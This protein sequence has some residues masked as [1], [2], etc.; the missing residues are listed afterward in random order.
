M[1][2]GELWGSCC[3]L[4]VFAAYVLCFGSA[5]WLSRMQLSR[6]AQ[7]RNMRVFTNRD[8]NAVWTEHERAQWRHAARVDR[9]CNGHL[10]TG[11]KHDDAR[12]ALAT[13]APNRNSRAQTSHEDSQLKFHNSVPP[14]NA[15]HSRQI[16]FNLDYLTRVAR[17]VHSQNKTFFQ[18]DY[19]LRLPLYPT[20]STL[21]APFKAR[22]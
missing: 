22:N 6:C 20:I 14:P 9:E 16:R 12:T 13:L 18:G 17:L 7:S 21:K 5:A 19:I 3:S 10:H 11:C 4:Q 2:E 15:I 1:G 8:Y